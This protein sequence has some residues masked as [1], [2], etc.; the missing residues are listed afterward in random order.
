MTEE[1]QGFAEWAVLELMG[2]RRLAGRMTEQEIAGVKFL[3]LDIP[4][5]EGNSATTQFYSPAAVYA[6]TPTTEAVA[7]AAAAATRLEPV[8]RWEMRALPP[9]PRQRAFDL[10]DLDDEDLDDAEEMTEP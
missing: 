4:E 3:R 7:R 1:T 5:S 2:H 8:A 10:E 9:A 6:I